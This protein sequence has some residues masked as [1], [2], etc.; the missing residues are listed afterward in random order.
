[1]A[2]WIALVLCAPYLAT[3]H[4]TQVIDTCPKESPPTA[5]EKQGRGM[6]R[7]KRARGT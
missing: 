6:A 7:R 1:M 5:A 3:A 2:A 4:V